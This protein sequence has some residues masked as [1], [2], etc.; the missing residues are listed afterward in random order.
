VLWSLVGGTAAW[1]LD[2][3]QDLALPVAGLGAF[4]LILWRKRRTFGPAAAA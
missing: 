3:A 4:A 2:V 1:F